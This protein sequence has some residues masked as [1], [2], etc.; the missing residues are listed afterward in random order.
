MTAH[1]AGRDQGKATRAIT[2]GSF[3]L[4]PSQ[5]LLLD[6]DTP[7][8]LGSRALDLLL[9]LVERAGEIV[10]NEEL[11]AR[12]WPNTAVADVSLR[13]HL[14]AIRRA[15]GDGQ[16]G[17]RYII[18]IPGR[19]Y[20]FV[21][22]VA[23]AEG[24]K[25]PEPQ[26]AAIE[27]IQALPSSRVR[28]V[29]RDGVVSVLA[30]QLLERR[31][32]SIVGPGGIG[33]TTVALAI[34][35]ALADT[36][37]HGVRFVDLG[38]LTNPRLVPSTL[39][40]TLA[41]ASRSENPT[42]EILSFLGDKQ[43]LLIFDS[44]EHVIETAAALAET[45]SGAAVGVHI[46]A[47]SREP[48][49][50]LGECVQRLSP[51]AVPPRSEGI[52]AAEALAYPAV[53][54]FVERAMANLDEFELTDASAPLVAEIC[55]RLDGIA[56]AIELAAGRLDAFGLRGVAALLDDRFRLLT[57]G[58]RT[59]LARHQTM[60]ATLD[61]SYDLLPEPERV[62]LRR[63]AIF[64][65]EFAREA[66]SAVAADTDI[67]S[68][69]TIE[70]I[71]NLVSKSLISAD[72]GGPAVRYRLLDTTRV[73]ALQKLVDS[74]ELDGVARRHADYYRTL[75]EQGQGQ[76][77]RQPAAH[78]VDDCGR[79][80]DNVRAALD[81]TFSPPGDRELGVALTVAAVPLWTHLSLDQECRGWVER[82]LAVLDA[83]PNASRHCQM[84]LYAALGHALTY[85]VGPLPQA[86]AAWTS[87][88]RLAEMLG[89]LDYQLRAHWGLAAYHS[90]RSEFL[91]A[92]EH[93]RTFRVLV[94]VRPEAAD[95]LVGDRIV[96]AVLHFLGD[97]GEARRQTERMLA[98]YP[99]PVLAHATRFQFDQ[100]ASARVILSWT[101][102]LQGF[103]DQA[104]RAAEAAVADAA[105]TD[106]A[107]S[108]CYAVGGGAVPIALLNG[109]LVT[110]ETLLATLRERST[111]HGLGVWRLAGR[112]FEG[113]LA[114][115]RGDA[116]LAHDLLR[117][118]LDELAH[119]GFALRYALLQGFLAQAQAQMG[120]MP[121]ALKSIDE[122]L[123][124]SE[125]SEELWCLPELL[126]INGVLLVMER[127]AAAADRAK[128]SFDRAI[129][130]A[131]QQGALS[132]ELRAATSL[133]RMLKDERRFSEALSLLQAV[134][135]KF[136]E[137]LETV[138]LKTAAALL[139]T[140]M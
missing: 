20:S 99:A 78:W 103:P 55:R 54:L 61:W 87:A 49:R 73:Y 53:Q 18:N 136:T 123:G 35:D 44:C 19:G 132:L 69:E 34:A 4:F 71:A 21:M 94:E 7:V 95:R 15:L 122:A 46:L 102:W 97:Q 62:I 1:D 13:V 33:K 51:L 84:R 52:A 75:F 134:H 66:A 32:L 110:A 40:A 68:A 48:L 50:A 82:A 83:A 80:L 2:F 108:M 14:A 131:R 37:H 58:R 111:T 8:R 72:V 74:G 96:G 36:Y 92:F 29:G 70:R 79:Q 106:H 89:D 30:A 127:G 114:L 126:R 65:G 86:G 118:G 98:G 24:Q 5:Q 113:V 23:I 59:A 105:A 42:P 45:V 16:S 63:I 88:L 137:G 91:L 104:M 38:S 25:P 138:D 125:G 76:W 64:A 130:L 10:S 121:E 41:M 17:R 116:V 129:T 139:E 22:P 43:M 47:T 67:S 100:R 12:V 6:G 117:G 31:F 56:L 101:L 107:L 85:T 39:A 135:G 3:R 28:M 26:I 124:R 119:V 60:S 90:S 27:R 133:A 11:L 120:R 112:C 93:A 115:S 77:L 109:D 81:W 9:V 57:Q 128:K 140:L